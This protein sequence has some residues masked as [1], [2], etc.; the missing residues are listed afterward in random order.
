MS[1]N[2]LNRPTEQQFPTT[3]AA[4]RLAGQVESASLSTQTPDSGEAVPPTK[5]L[6][7]DQ[8]FSPISPPAPILAAMLAPPGFDILG[9]LGRGGM[10]VVYHAR[11][12]RLKREVALKMILSGGHAS[13]EDRARF[14]AEAE[15][16]A[17][18][19]HPGIVQV[20]EF[21]THAGQPYFALE[22]CA[23]GSLAKR[24]DGTPLLPCD[25][26]SLVRRLAYAVQA[27]HEKG[28]VHRDLKPANVL[29][30]NLPAA[31]E[32]ANLEAAAES[33]F[34]AAYSLVSAVKISDFGLAKRT[35]SG[36]DL[37]RSGAVM[38]TPSYMAPEQALGEAKRIG[39]ATDVY[40]LGAILY[41]LLTGRPPFR[42]ATPYDTILQ[43][44]NDEPI[45]VR[46]LQKKVPPALVNVCHQCLRK[47]PHRRYASAKELAHDLGRWLNNEPVRARRIGTV[48][49][50]WLWCKR[51]PTQTALMASLLFGSVGTGV[52]AWRSNRQAVR[53]DRQL[54]RAEWLVYAG[55]IERAQRAL[56]EGDWK[57]ARRYLG[58][59]RW[60]Y[61]G[62]EW[63]YLASQYR[64][65]SRTSGSQLKTSPPAQT[66][67]GTSFSIAVSADSLVHVVS[68]VQWTRT[69]FVTRQITAYGPDNSVI[70]FPIP[71]RV[72]GPSRLVL[73]QD[74]SKVA[75][76][77]PDD[78]LQIWS[79]AGP[80]LYEVPRKDVVFGRPFSERAFDG[81][82]AFAS[83]CERFVAVVKK[84]QMKIWDVNGWRETATLSL[85]DHEW[86]GRLLFSPD[87]GFV[88][89]AGSETRKTVDLR[90][91]N[92]VISSDR[93]KHS[94]EL[95]VSPGATDV[96]ISAG[97][98]VT[99]INAATQQETLS[100]PGLSEGKC[101]AYSPD[102]T[103]LAL[104]REG[105][106]E[107]WALNSGIKLLTLPTP[108]R[109]I[110]SLS[111]SSDGSR[112]VPLQYWQFN[113]ASGSPSWDASAP[114]RI[115]L[116]QPHTRAIA[117]VAFSRDGRRAVGR[118]V[119]GRTVVWDLTSGQ[120]IP[121]A[122]D[123]Y[124]ESDE[125][126]SADG[127]ARLNSYV[128][129]GALVTELADVDQPVPS[130]SNR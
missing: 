112:L 29:M 27:A 106:V 58:E 68:S 116:L 122:G 6:P 125:S 32:A 91:G 98:N 84:T 114:E 14:L 102:G 20:Y 108:E 34:S 73:S 21:G 60:D 45:S 77:D 81:D 19:N 79:A 31:D 100:L 42:A 118:E 93:E 76:F 117:R 63:D 22:F 115:F 67:G 107:I 5:L 89:A 129:G 37:T 59:A 46:Q 104:G 23:G 17:A 4:Q 10:G 15:A 48:Q 24:L 49:R 121:E 72:D 126:V 110:E 87:G 56:S 55:Q 52:F 13:P 95:A 3:P 86:I 99:I 74:G 82:F 51:H 66:T 2:E 90:S 50:A 85:S 97:A 113:K 119:G 53:A 40:A 9:E 25:A 16:V 33:G 130:A 43:V 64:A 83:K 71:T 18:L 103:R 101:G 47:E 41:E 35:E 26:A 78:G 123:R 94:K 128:E 39:P 88:L 1:A 69:G 44:V 124:S 75:F 62:W 54:Q 92:V 28:I 38:G 109:R 80:K 8:A 120:I 57:A 70:P 105:T 7:A 61:R 111:F 127:N 36:Q 30:T 65:R 96:V 12:T 11:Q